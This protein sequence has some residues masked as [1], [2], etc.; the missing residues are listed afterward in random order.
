M[1][2]PPNLMKAWMHGRLR[3]IE[4]GTVCNPGLLGRSRSLCDHSESFMKYPG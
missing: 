3:E 1:K 4:L 2:T